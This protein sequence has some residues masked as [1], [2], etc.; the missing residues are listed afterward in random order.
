MRRDLFSALTLLGILL[1]ALVGCRGGA[2]VTYSTRQ[3]ENCTD[4]NLYV[5]R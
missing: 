2:E 4:Y 5:S 1:G 3:V